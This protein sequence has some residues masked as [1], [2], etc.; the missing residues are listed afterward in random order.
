LSPRKS[1]ESQESSKEQ[2]VEVVKFEA[3]APLEAK[4]AQK[5][6]KAKEVQPKVK[7]EETKE[8]FIP[9]IVNGER[10][11]YPISAIKN[12]DLASPTD[13]GV[14]KKYSKYAILSKGEGDSKTF[15]YVKPENFEDILINKKLT[16]ANTAEIRQGIKD[17]L[18]NLKKAWLMFGTAVAAVHKSRIYRVWGYE[19]FDDYCAQELQMHQSTVHE[20]IKSTIF[21]SQE[22][23]DLY[24]AFIAG[25]NEAIEQLPSYHSLYLLAAKEVKLGKERFTDLLQKVMDGQISSRDLQENIKDIE[26]KPKRNS[27]PSYLIKNYEGWY[28]RLKKIGL[29]PEIITKAEELLTLLKKVEQTK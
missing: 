9:A 17:S 24:R 8:D 3:T 14:D 28:E 19:T 7:N 16:P 20:I 15:Y 27:T 26:G 11:E 18:A 5:S 22:K 21:L 23:P 2:E 6:K 13:S 4:L 29:S 25:K 12:C 10:D 1:K